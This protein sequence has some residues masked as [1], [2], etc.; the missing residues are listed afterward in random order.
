M[1]TP[2]RY[3]VGGG[4]NS[5]RG[6]YVIPAYSVA[7]Q[8]MANQRARNHVANS[9]SSNYLGNSGN[10]AN[11]NVANVVHGMAMP[12]APPRND[13]PASNSDSQE[14]SHQEDLVYYDES[15]NENVNSSFIYGDDGMAMV[16]WI[17]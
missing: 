8:H 16:Y 7:N 17:V 10:L 1:G 9:G 4:R 6:I 15:D 2:A 12:R 3:G 14:I 5:G 13:K 11:P